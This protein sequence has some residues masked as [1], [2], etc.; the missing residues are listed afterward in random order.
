MPKM[1]VRRATN[2]LQQLMALYIMDI[3]GFSFLGIQRGKHNQ[4]A[5]SYD[6]I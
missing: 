6:I 2:S 3:A 4:R 1:K 5:N